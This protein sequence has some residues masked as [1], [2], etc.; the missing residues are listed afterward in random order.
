MTDPR[1]CRHTNHQPVVTTDPVTGDTEVVAR[2]CTDCLEQLPIGWA[3]ID[4]DW[5]EERVLCEPVPRL[6]LARPCREHS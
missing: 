2:I 1:T 5:V 6:L 3:C 4:C